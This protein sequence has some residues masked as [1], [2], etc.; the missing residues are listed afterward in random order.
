LATR[1]LEE[2]DH[3]IVKVMLANSSVRL[4]YVCHRSGIYASR[5]TGKKCCKGLVIKRINAHCPSSIIVTVESE[6]VKVQFGK[7]HV[8]HQID[9]GHLFLSKDERTYIAG[10]FLRIGVPFE[11]ILD[12]IRNSLNNEELSRKHLIERKDLHNIVRDFDLDKCSVHE[13]DPISVEQGI[14]D[15]SGILNKDDF[16]LCIMTEFQ[17]TM[18]E[19]FGNDKIC[20]DSTHGT[21]PY[22]FHLITLLIV[23]EFG[24]GCPAAFCVTNRLD[25][26]A[27]RLFFHA[28]KSKCGQ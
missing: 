18:L 4:V 2:R 12:D 11:R 3:V 19:K 14:Q 7:T 27:V 10:M 1:K 23:D 16:H 9:L 26:T 13:S 6:C 22:D 21:N 24:S 25:Y 8:G 5:T 28:I 15:E 20:V 17:A